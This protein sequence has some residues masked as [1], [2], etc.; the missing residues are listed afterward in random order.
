MAR[1]HENAPI[2][3]EIKMRYL[4][5]HLGTVKRRIGGWIPEL[6]AP[7]PLGPRKGVFGWESLYKPRAEQDP[8]DNHM[9]RRHL[10]SRAFWSHHSNWEG[11]LG[12]VWG[13]IVKLR[14]EASGM[15]TCQ[16][17]NKNRQYTQNYEDTALW[18][19][20]ELVSGRGTGLSYKFSGDQAGVVYGVGYVLE[21]SA[22]T[23]A[24]KSSIQKEHQGFV[25]R[26]TESKEMAELAKIWY[27]V[28]RLQEY[29][30]KIAGT[31]LKSSDIL[32]QCK[33]CRHLWKSP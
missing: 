28:L 27:E 29:M 1:M 31:V 30:G 5:Q 26:L 12:D 15:C 24:E 6:K 25:F 3:K 32:Y 4:T 21:T 23:A 14:T 2:V 8:D 20:F 19:A 33:F 11:N 22:I 18:E 10:R 17:T 9:I 13:T 16:S 7:S